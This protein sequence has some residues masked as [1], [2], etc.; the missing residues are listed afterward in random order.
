MENTNINW[1]EFSDGAILKQ[2]GQFI[3]KTRLAQNITQEE[4]MTMSGLN[5]STISKAEKGD[6]ITLKNLIQLLRSLDSLHVLN[7]FQVSDGI[8]PLEYA[9]LKKKNKQ[10]VRKK[11]KQDD[12]DDL[13]W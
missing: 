2:I 5:R 7:T 1:F 4:L 9:K 3:K 12:K 10:R 6:S 13:G 11:K 8:S